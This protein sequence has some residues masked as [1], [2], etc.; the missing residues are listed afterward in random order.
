MVISSH[1]PVGQGLE[2]LKAE[3]LMREVSDSCLQY[4][5]G[6]GYMSESGISRAYRD[7]HLDADRP[8][9]EGMS[10]DTA[11]RIAERRHS[12]EAREGISAFLA[13]RKPDWVRQ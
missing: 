5:R 13:K 3:R 10:E 6:A 4:S 11:R 1:E 2:M 12:A 9:D 7:M 8:V